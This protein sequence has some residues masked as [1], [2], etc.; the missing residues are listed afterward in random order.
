MHMF[1]FISENPDNIALLI[2]TFAGLFGLVKW[3]DAR[4][5]TLK[6]ERYDKYIQLIRVLSGSNDSKDASI[7]MSEQIASA[8]LLLEYKEYYPITLKILDNP[9]LERMT[10]EPWQEFILPQIKRV[11]KEIDPKS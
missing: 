10:N 6:N 4:T 2:A 5:L 9:D 8:W 11:I 7:S 3:L 1:E